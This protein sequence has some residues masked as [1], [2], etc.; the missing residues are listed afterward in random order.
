[1]I[2]SIITLSLIV[3]SSSNCTV[4]DENNWNIEVNATPV[5]YENQYESHDTAFAQ[6]LFDGQ[7]SNGPYAILQIAKYVVEIFED[8]KGHLWFGTMAKGVA[9]YDGKIVYSIPEIGRSE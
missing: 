2:K 9:R 3:F 8:S 4:A 7:S 1:M 6:L 5:Q